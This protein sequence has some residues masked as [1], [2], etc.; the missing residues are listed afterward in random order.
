VQLLGSEQG[1]PAPFERQFWFQE[2]AETAGPGFEGEPKPPF[3]GLR[4]SPH[5][6]VGVQDRADTAPGFER[7]PTTRLRHTPAGEAILVHR[8]G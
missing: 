3:Q 6:R 1:S 8:T 7:G 2:R 5:P 4:E